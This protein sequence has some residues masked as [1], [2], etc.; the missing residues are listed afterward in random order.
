MEQQFQRLAL[1]SSA[2]CLSSSFAFATSP[3]SCVA[4]FSSSYFL[5]LDLLADRN[6]SSSS[7]SSS[8]SALVSIGGPATE[9]S[10]DPELIVS[11]GVSVVS[12]PF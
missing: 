3:F 7:L 4:F 1:V 12:L 6:F 9:Y 10:A 2:C 8:L 11:F 5:P